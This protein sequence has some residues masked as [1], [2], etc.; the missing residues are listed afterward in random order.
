MQKA[1]PILSQMT[2]HQTAGRSEET[3]SEDGGKA[4]SQPTP[5]V[6]IVYAGWKLEDLEDRVEKAHLRE[7]GTK[8]AN[9]P[10]PL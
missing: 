10:S 4:L 8:S 9:N 3:G 5:L 2:L 6:Q 1:G 7:A